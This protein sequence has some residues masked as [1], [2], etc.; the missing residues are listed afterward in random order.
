MYVGC[1]RRDFFFDNC[2][3]DIVYEYEMYELCIHEM[4][5]TLALKDLSCF[6]AYN[7]HRDNNA[8]IHKNYGH[9]L[10]SGFSRYK[11]GTDYVIASA[12]SKHGPI[13]SDNSMF[14][15]ILEVSGEE[16]IL[17]IRNQIEKFENEIRKNGF[18][19]RLCEYCQN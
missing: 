10:D 13:Y 3:V 9:L 8:T 2:K 17:Y 15:S 1:F 6:N 16:Y 11:V 19:P 7:R 12:N 5:H 14:T 18:R 4:Q